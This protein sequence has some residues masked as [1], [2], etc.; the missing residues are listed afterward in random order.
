[1]DNQDRPPVAAP[2]PMT[3]PTES[4]AILTNYNAMD[5]IAKYAELVIAELFTDPKYKAARHDIRR[6]AKDFNPAYWQVAH[7]PSAAPVV[8]V[9]RNAVQEAA[10]DFASWLTREMPPGTV[11][12]SPAWW[13]PRIFSYARIALRAASVPQLAVPQGWHIGNSGGAIVVQHHTIGGAVVEKDEGDVRLSIFYEF[14]AA[15]LKGVAPAVQDAPSD[16]QPE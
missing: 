10:K 15:V 6:L 14:L 2:I 16:E 4:A 8:L 11:I 3:A 9:D 13:A 12:A 5:A 7:T 1:M